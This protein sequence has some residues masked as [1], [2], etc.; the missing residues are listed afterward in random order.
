MWLHASLSLHLYVHTHVDV[1]GLM[2][3]YIC[4]HD[5]GNM[6]VSVGMNTIIW[7]YTPDWACVH[8]HTR[9]R[10][11]CYVYTHRRCDCTYF[12]IHV[13][14][15]SCL[16]LI[17]VWLHLCE[18]K[19]VSILTFMQTQTCWHNHAGVYIHMWAWPRLYVYTCVRIITLICTCMYRPDHTYVNTHV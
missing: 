18:H 10:H 6:Q 15:Y 1:V 13:C 8:I 4:G 7:K 14:P 12:Y 9:G 3:A 2:Y 17:D 19:R 5:H 16:C 11:H